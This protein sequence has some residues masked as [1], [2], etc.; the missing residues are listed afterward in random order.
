MKIILLK[1]V[2]KVGKKYDIKDVADG[3]ALNMLIPRGLAMSATPQ[4]VKKV[5]TM[6]QNDTTDK[7][8]QEDLLAKNLEVIKTLTITLKEKAN[9]KG[10]LFAG[11]TKEMLATEI[12]K[13]TRLNI[14]PAFIKLEKPI[15]EIGEHKVGIEAMG[16]KAEFTVVVEAK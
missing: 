16:K 8:I 4:A 3:H 12:L 15:K 6:K 5:E 7:K 9:D 13:V 11:I 14:D 1:D 10:H 2:Q